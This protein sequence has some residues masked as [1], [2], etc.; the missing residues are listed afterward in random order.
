MM[1]DQYASQLLRLL[2]I[3]SSLL[4]YPA[5]IDTLTEDRVE[6]INRERYFVAETVED[7]CRLL[8]GHAVLLNLGKRLKEECHKVSSLSPQQQLSEWHGIESCLYAMQSVSRYIGDDEDKILPFI[9]D[10]IP[11]LP[12]D[13]PQMRCTANLT[14]GKYALWLDSHTA[15]LQP[16]MPYLAQGLSVPRCAS[17]AA[18][19]IKE[20]CESCNKHLS[21]GD[22]VLDLYDGIIAAQQQSMLL[23]LRDELEVLEGACKA[24]SRQLMDQAASGQPDT[25]SN[26]TNRLVQPIGTRLAAI[27]APE[28]SYHPKQATTEVERLTVIIRYL[29]LPR[30]TQSAGAAAIAT[31]SGIQMLSAKATFVLNL[32]SESWNLLEAI[33]QKYPHDIHLAEKLCRLH[34]HTL[35]GCGAAAYRPM[36]EPL[37]TQLVRNFTAST[38]SPY[39]YAASICVSEYC[40]DAEAVPLLFRMLSDMS[41]AV[42]GLLHSPDKFTA[43]P[44]VVEEFFFLGARM[45]SNC[46]EPL[47]MSPLLNHY[48]KYASEGMK[49]D[50]RDANSGTLNFIE[51][52]ISYGLTLRDEV[53]QRPSPNQLACKGMLEKAIVS[54]GQAIIINMAASLL[55]DLPLYRLD[56]GRGSIAG[57]LFKLNDLCPDLLMQWLDSALVPAPGQAKDEFLRS[58]AIRVPRDKF[59]SSV[60]QF[61]S[62]CDRTRKLRGV[63]SAHSA[64][65]SI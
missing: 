8:G 5:D 13:V 38:L 15:H 47:V 12:P 65:R 24:I 50:H 52:T 22:P 4:C 53:A 25:S 39:L 36:L 51:N 23:D 35:R 62:I 46:P 37:C 56:N 40:R 27:A 64:R 20:L 33:S 58:F 48:L 7:C 14:V 60:R 44:D 28:G 61:T 17:S 29:D 21:L 1:I 18:I 55:G 43:H 32:T 49:L 34:K 6:D 42:F 9:M 54:E 63:S 45:M 11:R 16:L 19:A 26:Y 30:V 2:S 31:A 3:C 10:L 57:I 41:T 59:D